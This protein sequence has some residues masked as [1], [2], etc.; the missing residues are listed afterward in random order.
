MDRIWDILLKLKANHNK[1]YS[2]VKTFKAASTG[3]LL[4]LHHNKDYSPEA[5]ARKQL[6]LAYL[7]DFIF[8]N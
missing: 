5:S 8:I 4:F 3:R 1:D 7:R 6:A 2:V